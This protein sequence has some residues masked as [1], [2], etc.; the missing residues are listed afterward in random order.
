MGIAVSSICGYSSWLI[1][2]LGIGI[3]LI[4][5]SPA[6]LYIWPENYSFL[7]KMQN[8]IWPDKNEK[9]KLYL[10]TKNAN[11]YLAIKNAKKVYIYECYFCTALH[12]VVPI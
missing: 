1:V 4:P 8:Y 10:A 7:E 11:L 5:T 12:Y 3:P 6:S 2:T 9:K